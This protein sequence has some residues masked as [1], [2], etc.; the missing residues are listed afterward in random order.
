MRAVVR[1]IDN[2]SRFFGAI[3][4]VL[5]I[6]LV[7][8]MLYDVV[9]R[10]VLNAPTIWG[11][12][13]NTWLMGASFVLSIA[14]AMSTDSHVRVDLLYNRRTRRHIRVFDLIGLVL[15]ILPTVTWITAGLFDHFVT[16]Y[17]NGERSGSGGWNPIVWP[18]KAILLVGFAVFTVQI[19]AE[20]IKRIA[21]LIGQPFEAPEETT[22]VHGV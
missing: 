13:L 4:A 1:A 22:D 12:D 20:I 19:V 15:I 14:Y 6:V 21:S 11:N 17:Q 9:L 18:F 8:L 2:I 16:A 10:Y 5:V 3:A 7:V